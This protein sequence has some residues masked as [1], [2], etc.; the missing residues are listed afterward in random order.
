MSNN[1]DAAVLELYR[2]TVRNL[3]AGDRP[4]VVPNSSF[5]HAT[6]IL[7]ELIRSA[8]K[9]F[10]AF[11]GRFSGDVWSE[12]VKDA[13]IAAIDRGINVRIVISD[14]IDAK[15]LP[16]ALRDHISILDEEKI[17]TNKIAFED[18]R[19]FAVVDGKSLRLEDNRET[20][21]ALFAA[22]QPGIASELERI[23]SFLIDSAR[24]A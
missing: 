10:Y 7:E 18:I 17:K 9:S 20:R 19:H 13:L 15:S 22:N 1:N 14:E 24:A 23:F 12:S 3:L 6:I 2:M 16:M 11:C 4:D 21:E 5:R 8:R